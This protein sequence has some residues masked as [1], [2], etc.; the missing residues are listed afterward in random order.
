VVNQ[1]DK[2]IRADNALPD[3]TSLAVC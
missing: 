3:P 2:L 1:V